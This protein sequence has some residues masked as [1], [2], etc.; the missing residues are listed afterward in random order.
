MTGQLCPLLLSSHQTLPKFL[1]VFT[2]RCKQKYATQHQQFRNQD[3]D[4]DDTG[5]VYPA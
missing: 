4:H 5:A 2:I 1:C 3:E